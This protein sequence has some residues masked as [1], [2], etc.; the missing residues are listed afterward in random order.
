MPNR[1][2]EMGPAGLH[3]ARAIE[4]LRLARGLTQQQLA[5]RCTALGRPMT[6]TALSRTERARRRCDIDDLVVIA[7]ALGISPAVLLPVEPAVSHTAPKTL[8]RLQEALLG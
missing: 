7:I 2:V 4:H 5:A 8:N 3:A 1:P 6:N